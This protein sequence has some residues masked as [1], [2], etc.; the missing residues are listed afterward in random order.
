VHS[1]GL[2]AE[3]GLF[4]ASDSF[5]LKR[6]SVTHITASE[7]EHRHLAHTQKW[8]RAHEIPGGEIFGGRGD[9]ARGNDMGQGQKHRK[10]RGGRPV[11]RNV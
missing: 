1:N 6:V 4:F 7:T 5:R 11:R 8:E 2:F 3:L 10:L 9:P